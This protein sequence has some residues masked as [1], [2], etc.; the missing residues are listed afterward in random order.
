MEESEEESWPSLLRLTHVMTITCSSLSRA[1]VDPPAPPLEAEALPILRAM[2]NSTC[3]ASSGE[4]KPR[5]LVSWMPGATPAWTME[6]R[7]ES[8]SPER[9]AA[10]SSTRLARRRSAAASSAHWSE[11]VLSSS[12][13]SAKACSIFCAT[14]SSALSTGADDV[15]VPRPRPEAPLAAALLLLLTPLSLLPLPPLLLLR[16]RGK[17]PHRRLISAT[18]PGPTINLGG[19]FSASGAPIEVDE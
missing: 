5:G 4:N 10:S 8:A 19:A 1:L 11:R 12:L 16:S 14:A 3:A 7:G 17:V 15:P 13:A 18:T 2:S 6:K 9:H